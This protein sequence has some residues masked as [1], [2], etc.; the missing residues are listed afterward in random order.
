MEV[1]IIHMYVS[2]SP[3]EEGWR[4]PSEVETH[5]RW[6]TACGTF[7]PQSGVTLQ[8]F[9]HQVSNEPRAVN[10]PMCKKSP[11]YKMAMSKLGV[12]A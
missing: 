11:V 3:G 4:Q 12:Q 8:Q 9:N 7:T 1:T 10:C 2:V 6:P 5:S